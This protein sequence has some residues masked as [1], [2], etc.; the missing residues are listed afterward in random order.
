MGRSDPGLTT[1]TSEA[2]ICQQSRMRTAG[3]LSLILFGLLVLLALSAV[4]AEEEENSLSEELAEARVVRSP[5]AA[6]KKRRRN[7][8]NG[9]RRQARRRSGKKNGDNRRRR[10][11]K[12]KKNDNRRNKQAQNSGSRRGQRRNNRQKPARKTP[13]SRATSGLNDNCFEQAV[14]FMKVWKDIVG[15]FEKQ[16]KRMVKQNKTGG[17]KSGKKGLFAPIAHRLGDI[18]GGNKTNMSCGGEY[19]NKGAAQLQNLTKTLFD[20]EIDVNKSCNPSNFPK[21]NTTLTTLCDS[22]VSSFT[23]AT[24]ACLNKTFGSTKTNVSD[25][26]GC[27]VGPI[28]NNT[29][30]S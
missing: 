16:R 7:G 4:R 2:D 26:C 15:N 13:E 17:N 14:H 19:G 30:Q 11:R 21:P 8:R 3:S 18:G 9:G 1:S 6:K 23:T 20:C 10:T 5:E 22:L 27:W 28:L 12:M 24:T 29:A 25:A